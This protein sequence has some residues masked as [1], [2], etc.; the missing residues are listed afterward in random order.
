MFQKFKHPTH[1]N[2]K[3]QDKT[4]LSSDSPQA[5]TD[6]FSGR[7]IGNNISGLNTPELPTST[8]F[9]RPKYVKKS[10]TNDVW[11]P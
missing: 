6:T 5:M 4:N 11:L 3:P 8:H 10:F 9:L 7:P 2:Y 1:T